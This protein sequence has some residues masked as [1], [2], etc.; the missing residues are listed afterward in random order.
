MTLIPLPTWFKW[1]SLCV[2]LS[3][4]LA[5]ARGS[6]ECLVDGNSSRSRVL[7]DALEALA[8]ETSKGFVL[9]IVD[10]LVNVL[11]TVSP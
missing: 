1:L 9:A 6:E 7:N 10:I 5:Q 3:A 11:E 8:L 4:G 2:N